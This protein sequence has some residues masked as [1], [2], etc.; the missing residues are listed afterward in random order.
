MPVPPR[1]PSSSRARRRAALVGLVAALGIGGAIVASGADPI[2]GE[3]TATEVAERRLPEVIDVVTI[4]DSGELDAATKS[5]AIDAAGRA[6]ANWSVVQSVSSAMTQVRRGGWVLQGAPSGYSY[7]MSTTFLTDDTI[8]TLMGGD[9]LTG[10]TDRTLVMSSGTAAL[11]GA[12]AGDVVTLRHVAGGTRDFTITQIVDDAI[13]GGTE[14]LMLPSAATR[15][16]ISR[17]SRVLIWGFADRDSIMQALAA[18]GVVQSASAGPGNV[19]DPPGTPRPIRLRRSWDPFDPDST[20]GMARTKEVLGEFAYL[21]NSNGSVTVDSAWRSANI[22]SNPPRAIGLTADCHVAIEPALQNALAEIA[23]RGLSWTIDLSNSNRFGGCFVPRFNR[24]TPNSSVGFLSRHTW[25][26]AID[27]NTVDNCQGCAPPGFART[28]GGCETVRIFRKHG[29]SWGGN[30]TTP[31]GMHFEYVGEDR[32]QV[33]YPSRWCSNEPTSTL[34]ELPVEWTERS[35]MFADSGLFE[36][37]GHD[38][39]DDGHDH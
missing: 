35:V 31:D 5:R 10:L 28:G 30:Y 39:G 17:E 8:A 24:L 27:M 4:H 16:G 6:G 1:R 29:F 14:L 20:L 13:T 32:S 11:R 37:H 33:P 3:A 9:V 36:G 25:G 18:A 12:Q 7:P 26:M 15:L 19:Y 21:L 34:L 22:P 2:D 38:D 23:T